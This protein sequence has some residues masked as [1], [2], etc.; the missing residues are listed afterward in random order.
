MKDASV[1]PFSLPPLLQPYF[2][3]VQRENCVGYALSE[4]VCLLKVVLATYVEVQTLREVLKFLLD[5]SAYT[6]RDVR[7]MRQRR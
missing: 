5:S 3:L 4:I 2:V 1:F 7:A 6:P